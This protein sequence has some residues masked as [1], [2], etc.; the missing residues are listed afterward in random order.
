MKYIKVAM[1]IIITL[2]IVF[3]VAGCTYHYDHQKIKDH[4]KDSGGQVI[5]IDR[6]LFF[7]NN[8]YW[9]SNSKTGRVYKFKYKDSLG[10]EY[11][12]WVKTGG[13]ISHWKM[14]QE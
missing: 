7:K 8:P 2:M 12:G 1:M 14:E 11:V 4:V 6:K 13:I 5:D 3:G 9:F 10:K